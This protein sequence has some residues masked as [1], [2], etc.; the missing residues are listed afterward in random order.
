ML[1]RIYS[2]FYISSSKSYVLKSPRTEKV[3][4]NFEDVYK[5]FKKISKPKLW[6][7]YF[8]KEDGVTANLTNS[9]PYQEF[10]PYTEEQE[11]ARIQ[12]K[13]EYGESGLKAVDCQQYCV[14]VEEAEDEALALYGH[15]GL[16]ALK[17]YNQ[18]LDE[19]QEQKIEEVLRK[20]KALHIFSRRGLG[21]VLIILA[22]N[23][24]VIELYKKDP[25]LRF[26][27]FKDCLEE[28]EKA[29]YTIMKF[30][31]TGLIDY[32]GVVLA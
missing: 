17:K 8:S 30:L 19:A 22:G 12:I 16:E 31:N 15:S 3:F 18:L 6:V 2:I 21:S 25:L 24:T 32:S 29:K 28:R 27:I 5:A 9:T 10:K 11:A 26:T 4:T 14:T 23:R 7:L 20:P 1:L 13:K